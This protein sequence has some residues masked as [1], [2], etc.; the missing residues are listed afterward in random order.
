MI[1]EQ[2]AEEF[3][4]SLPRL[5]VRVQSIPSA[6]QAGE[7]TACPH[8]AEDDTDRPLEARICLAHPGRIRCVD[9]GEYH[10]AADRR[11]GDQCA[12][13]GRTREVAH[14][15]ASPVS[16]PLELGGGRILDLSIDAVLCRGCAGRAWLGGGG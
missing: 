4:Q 8:L 16:W 2:T 1:L 7:V 13:C 14:L 3:A 12:E 11:R 10:A 5:W 6:L 15:V 9:C